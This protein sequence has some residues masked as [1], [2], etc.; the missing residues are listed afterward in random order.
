MQERTSVLEQATLPATVWPRL[1]G[2][3]G[4]FLQ[5]SRTWMGRN[6]QITLTQGA[7]LHG[8]NAW[9]HQFLLVMR[10]RKAFSC[11]LFSSIQHQKLVVVLS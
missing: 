3:F 2:G 10:P 5:A 6:K 1:P 4:P 7:S 8:F 11:S 9:C